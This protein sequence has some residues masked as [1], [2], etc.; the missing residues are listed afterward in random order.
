MTV[1]KAM[2]KIQ[3]MEEHSLRMKKKAFEDVKSHSMNDEIIITYGDL[4]DML[5]D[6]EELIAIYKRMEVDYR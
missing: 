3:E 6:R 1:G 5:A 2:E 4:V